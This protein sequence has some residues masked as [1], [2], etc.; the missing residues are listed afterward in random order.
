M[1]GRIEVNRSLAPV[2]MPARLLNELRSHAL[3]A[4][5]EECCGL[6]V[7]S[8][9]GRFEA[10]HRCR[11]DMTR[12]HRQDPAAWPRDGTKA[13]HMNEI[14][15]LRVR[16]QA[17]AAGGRVTGVY[18]SHVDAP[19]YFS[20]L[21]QEYVR[22]PLFPFPDARHLVLSVVEGRVREAALFRIDPATG[23]IEGRPVV[24]RAE[25]R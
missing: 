7:G 2:C 11:N 4:W 5:P 14:D 13:F 18:H 16:D 24:P 23:A 20:E 3:E 12:L 22:Q 9:P 6:L 15:Y 25:A 1:S 19:A 10:A 21:D 17:E 8:A